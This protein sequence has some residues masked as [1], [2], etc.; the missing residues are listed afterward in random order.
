MV[1]KLLLSDWK[2]NYA[3]LFMT[4]LAVALMHVGSG[5]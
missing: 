2:K 1:A 5:S 3:R 4:L